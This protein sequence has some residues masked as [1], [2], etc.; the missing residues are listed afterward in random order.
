M[1]GGGGLL[2]YKNDPVIIVNGGAEAG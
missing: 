1:N 2:V